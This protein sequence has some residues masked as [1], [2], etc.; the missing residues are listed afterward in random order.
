[1]DNDYSLTLTIAFI[2]FALSFLVIAITVIPLQIKEARVVNGL[3]KLRR[4]MLVMGVSTLT[5]ALLADII[6][7]IALLFPPLRWTLHLLIMLLSFSLLVNAMAK[8]RVYHDQYT[9][10]HKEMS[11]KIQKQIDKKGGSS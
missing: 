8:Y 5:V 6:L 10:E 9:P 3:A 4:Q 2:C 1:M 11:R 7:A